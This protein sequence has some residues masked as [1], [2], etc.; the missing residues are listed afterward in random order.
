M[1]SLDSFENGMRK[2]QAAEDT[3]NVDTD[4]NNTESQE[5][6]KKKRRQKARRQFSSSEESENETELCSVLPPFP[7]S[8][9][10]Q[11]GGISSPSLLKKV[12]DGEKNL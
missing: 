1:S 2:L 4:G 8:K 10:K 9:L 12:L 7:G 11:S 6:A 3:S 5:R